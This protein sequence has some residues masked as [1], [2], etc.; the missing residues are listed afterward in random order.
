MERKVISFKTYSA[1]NEIS[2]QKINTPEI[3]LTE[4][5]LSQNLRQPIF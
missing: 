5:G 3:N 4:N 1:T 2:L